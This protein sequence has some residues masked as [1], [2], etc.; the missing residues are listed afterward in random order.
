V[1]D[2]LEEAKATFRAKWAVS[3]WN[4]TLEEIGSGFRLGPVTRTG[5]PMPEE[6]LQS[7]S[8]STLSGADGPSD[9]PRALG[10]L[11]ET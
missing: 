1:A 10:G 7:L 3:F 5:L 4:R 11:P 9:I 6:A 2:T 8:T